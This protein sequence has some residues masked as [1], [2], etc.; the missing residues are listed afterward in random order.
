MT[1]KLN[2]KLVALGVLLS[3]LVW[4]PSLVQAAEEGRQHYKE[5]RDKIVKELNLAPDKLK[6]FQALEEK[7][8]KERKESR[9]AIKKAYD[10][11]DKLMAAGKPDEAKVKELL[12]NINAAQEKHW[13]AHKAQMKAEMALMTPEQQAKYLLA[14]RHWRHD[15]MERHKMKKEAEQKK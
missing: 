11:L 15:M 13:A 1:G 3:A 8:S 10:D 6:E 5:H 9:D 7:F 4:G 14:H 2:F 12:S